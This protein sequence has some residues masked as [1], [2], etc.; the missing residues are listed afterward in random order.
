MDVTE[1]AVSD[2][3][4]LRRIRGGE[5]DAATAL[6]LR[7]VEH[8]Q[9]L[10]KRQTSPQLAPR[11]DSEDIVQSI[12]RTLFRRVV[13]DHYDVPQGEDL[14]KLIL[15]IALHK[16]RNAAARHRSAKRDVTKTVSM[17]GVPAAADGLASRDETALATLRMVIAE[18]SG[19]LPE[20]SR[21][22]VEL[23]IDGYEVTEIASRT[24]RSKRSVERVL[25]LFRERLKVALHEQR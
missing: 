23:R 7:Y 6:Y 20:A 1:S 12:F 10:V 16:V 15:V 3:S 5:G 25:Q 2:H 9:S 21:R 17:D 11:L 13:H 18:V 4:L 19:P 8:L 22:I 14:W 24:G